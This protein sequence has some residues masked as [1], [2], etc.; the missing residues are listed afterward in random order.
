ML[1]TRNKELLLKCVARVPD[2]GL[3]VVDRVRIMR[4]LT[5]DGTSQREEKKGNEKGDDEKGVMV[6][7]ERLERWGAGIQTKPM[8]YGKWEY[9]RKSK[10]KTKG[11]REKG[12]G[13]K[14]RRQPA[15]NKKR[16]NQRMQQNNQAS[17]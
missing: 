17:E 2:A 9:Q 12:E 7:S 11:M 3:K 5:M 8:E 10:A 1:I 15:A 16:Q 13:A 6:I 14:V 4:F